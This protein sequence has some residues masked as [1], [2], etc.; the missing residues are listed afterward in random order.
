MTL[1][2]DTSDLVKVY[3]DGAGS[4][5]IRDLVSG[6]DAVVTSAITY[7][8]VRATFVRRRLERRM[9]PAQKKLG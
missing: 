6:A 1:Y 7:A 4:A 5:E 3:I 9:T 2:L 8:E